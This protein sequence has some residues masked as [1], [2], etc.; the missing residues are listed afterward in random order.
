MHKKPLDPSKD[1]DIQFLQ[2]S[3]TEKMVN[4]HWNTIL[5]RLG[6]DNSANT[7]NNGTETKDDNQANNHN[8]LN[9]L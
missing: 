2:P 6:E 8:G 7:K 5:L 1:L 9:P 3:V 4:E